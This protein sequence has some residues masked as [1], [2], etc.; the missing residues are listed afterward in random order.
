MMPE[1]LA[2]FKTFPKLEDF[3]QIFQGAGTRTDKVFLV[4]K[5]GLSGGLAN[6]FSYETNKEYLIEL[7][8][9]KK[10]IRGRD[11]GRYTLDGDKWWLIVPY[12]VKKGRYSLIPYKIISSFSPRL[13]DYLKECKPRLD[14]REQGR[15]KG[16]SWYGYARPQNLDRFEAP[17]KI[18]LPDVIDR[19]KCYLDRE[20]TWIVD[21]VYGIIKNP[22]QQ[23]D[24]RYILGL[25]NSPLLTYYLKETGTTLRDGFF[26]M[27]TA[28]L[29]PFPLRPIDFSNPSD[30]NRHH[31]IINLV[32]GMLTLHQQLAAALTPNE[33]TLLQ[34]Q[35]DATDSE[36]N[37]LVYQLYGLTEEE[38]KIVEGR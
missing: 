8:F 14:Q 7:N 13:V 16:D 36:I 5:H 3:A 18:I 1:L 17:E 29:Q 38:I 19:G 37:A 21:T 35:V 32:E 24:I 23:I 11:I 9:L 25:L 4:E 22:D 27:K 33:K 26:R 34:R 30:I 10:A 31:Q 20:K 6:V 12:Q 28:Y 15:F 2:K